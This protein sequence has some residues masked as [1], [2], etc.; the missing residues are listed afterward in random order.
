MVN[1]VGSVLTLFGSTDR[2]NCR[3]VTY[4]QMP[5]PAK[6]AQALPL[7]SI[8]YRVGVPMGMVLFWIGAD[9]EKP[10][11]PLWVP[12]VVVVPVVGVEE[13]LVSVGSTSDMVGST[14]VEGVKRV[15]RASR[16]GRA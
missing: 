11:L 9:G 5:C 12:V 7:G 4:C 14:L 8:W 16:R 13:M 10:R 6:T 1:S 2:H 3:L 15:S